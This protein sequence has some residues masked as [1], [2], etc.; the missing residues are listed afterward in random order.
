MITRDTLRIEN[1]LQAY[2][3]M[4]S[5]TDAD[6][7]ALEWNGEYRH[8]RQ[9]YH[10]IFHSARQGEA[11][12][13]VAELPSSGVIGQLFVQLASTRKELADGVTRAYIY[14][15]RIQPAY[16]RKGIGSFMLR[17]VEEDLEKR[18]FQ[19]VCLNVTKENV[20]ARRLYERCGYAIVAVEAGY[21]SY[22]DE[23]GTRQFVHEPSWRMEKQI[24]QAIRLIE[25]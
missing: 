1:Y 3:R 7:P 14:G 23:N 24:A 10:E 20:D 4:R 8:F 6:L 11:L 15:F 21:W 5:A 22:V 17:Y 13:W 25:R 2:I 18:G 9:L 12:L 19:C 16:R